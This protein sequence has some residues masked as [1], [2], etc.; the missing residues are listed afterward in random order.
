MKY[1]VSQDAVDPDIATEPVATIEELTGTDLV[2]A[3]GY[4]DRWLGLAI[5][6]VTAVT[7]FGFIGNALEPIRAGSDLPVSSSAASVPSSVAATAQPAAYPVQTSIML[8]TAGGMSFSV[9][10]P[11]AIEA[12]RGDI[13]LTVDGDAPSSLNTV[14]IAVRARSGRVLASSVASVAMGDERPGS[15]GAARTGSGT[16][17]ARIV[18][19]GPIPSAG[20]LVEISWRDEST[21]SSGSV[22]QVIAAIVR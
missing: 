20:W 9:R 2:R 12:P 22:S 17:C 1:L 18:V 13:V 11:V 15:R 5:A 3:T 16:L 19:A 8:N 7:C 6:V 4:T 21:N 10:R 14:A